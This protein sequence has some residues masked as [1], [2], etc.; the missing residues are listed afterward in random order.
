MSKQMLHVVCLLGLISCDEPPAPVAQA[1]TKT[2]PSPEKAAPR[3]PTK[4]LPVTTK[5][6]TPRFDWSKAPERFKVEVKHQN[7]LGKT[8]SKM[9]ML[10][11]KPLEN[12]GYKLTFEGGLLPPIVVGRDGVFQG[13]GDLAAFTTRHPK[14]AE[15][16]HFAWLAST[17]ASTQWNMT[18]GALHK[19]TSEP[20]VT[21]TEESIDDETLEPH[22]KS[23]TLKSVGAC[24]KA[25]PT[26]VCVEME[27]Q[28]IVASPKSRWFVP[29]AVPLM[30]SM[31]ELIFTWHVKA[32]IRT[33]LPH[34][35][36]FKATSVY[37]DMM[38]DDH[39][40]TASWT[41]DFKVSP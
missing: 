33:L 10:T 13:A 8:S 7:H 39:S 36:R 30:M 6:V 20:G 28:L 12:G 37:G 15:K 41:L 16:S 24:S 4:P 35:I 38:P 31:R 11:Q 14:L 21:L 17:L 34:H 22:K 27:S 29:D 18:L 25:T 9:L 5:A 32:E 26:P 3:V 40:R 23:Y 2:P 1:P 19:R